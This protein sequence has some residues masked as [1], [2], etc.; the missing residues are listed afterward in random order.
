MA[1]EMTVAVIGITRAGM[2][3]SLDGGLA[4][5]VRSDYRHIRPRVYLDFIGSGKFF[6]ASGVDVAVRSGSSC[7]KKAPDDPGP[8]REG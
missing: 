1:S 3:E 7:A 6:S 5:G 2:K 8:V 4:T